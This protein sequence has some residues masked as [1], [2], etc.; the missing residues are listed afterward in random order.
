MIVKNVEKQENNTALFQV[1]SD[2]AE[3]EAAVN[4]VYLQNK[5]SIYIPG[6]RKGKAPRA[7]VEGMYG[8]DVF[9]QDALDEL[10]PKAFEQGVKESELRF[11]GA[12]SISDVNVTDERTAV[13][14][15]S[16]TLYPEVTLGQY[17]GIEATRE[18]VNVTDEDVNAEVESARKR[19]ARKVSVEREAQMGDTA[20]IDFDGFLNGERF[21][22]GKAEGYDLELGS[23]SFVP[24]FEEQ[25][26]GMQIGEEK[27]LDITFP[28]EYV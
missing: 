19:N 21:D 22:G 20:N 13:F 17:K 10:A 14:T 1:E 7:V 25:V 9:Y 28:E 5:A 26:V 3:F 2:A 23:N 8:K 6:F 27:D 4:S 12:P 18:T 24:G 15:F 11:V 16:V